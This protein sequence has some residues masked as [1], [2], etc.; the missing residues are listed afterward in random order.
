M[1]SNRLAS[2]SLAHFFVGLMKADGGLS[3]SE[4]EKIEIL[5][6]KMRHHLPGNYEH[7]IEQTRGIRHAEEYASWVPGEHLEKGLE[8][9]DKFVA[10]GGSEP[11]HF[12]GIMETLEIIM[13]V[14]SITPGE[15]EYID[16]MHREFTQKYIK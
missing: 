3:I 7:T 1:S 14:G 13:E 8:F 15:K 4:E 11:D 9:L 12:T 2:N 16:R 10:S 5:I 6:Y